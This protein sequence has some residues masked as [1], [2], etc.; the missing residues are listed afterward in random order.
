M[1]MSTPEPAKKR[2]S[3]GGETPTR[4]MASIISKTRN[5]FSGNSPRSTAAVRLL[6]TPP[7]KRS[8]MSASKKQ[9]GFKSPSF[10]S[11][12]LIQPLQNP[13]IK[14]LIEQKRQLE[15]DVETAKDNIRKMKLLLTYQEKVSYRFTT[16]FRL[17]E[18]LAHNAFMKIMILR[19]TRM[20]KPTMKGSLRSGEEQVRKLPNSYSQNF[21]NRHHHRS[22]R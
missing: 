18:G 3:L 16:L 14:A 22:L 6:H 15:K 21:P 10:K 12:L 17:S 2:I 4:S 13:E 11:P 19:K 20:K 8:P 5:K 7:G 1:S 9:S